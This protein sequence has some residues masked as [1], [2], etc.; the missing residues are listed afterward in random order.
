MG[1][2]PTFGKVKIS[3]GWAPFSN[4]QDYGFIRGFLSDHENVLVNAQ[5]GKTKALRQWRF[6]SIDELEESLLR[7]YIMEAV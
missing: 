6:K 2:Q 3:L 4:T 7:S 5:K 1:L